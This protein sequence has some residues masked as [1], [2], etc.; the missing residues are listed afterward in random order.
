M[1]L[2]ELASRLG[3]PV[4]GDADFEVRGA[5]ALES[6]GPADLCFVAS[7]RYAAL[8]DKSGAG[9]AILPPDVERGSRPA[10]RSPRPRL[11]FARA[12]R[13]LMPEPIAEPGVHPDASVAP[14][15]RIDPT[16]SV[17][18]R[19][20]V[21]ARSQVGPRSVLHPNATLYEDVEI[22]ADCRIHAGVV[23]RE[24]TLLGDRV[25]LQ[26]GVMIGGDGFGYESGGER[27]FE[28][29][30][31]VGRVVIEDDV[32]IG[33]STTVD[34]APPSTEPRSARRASARG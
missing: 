12:L 33:A 7:A 29:V 15:A 1:R 6:A 28:T 10:I 14:D 19:A 8:L 32:E 3:R 22:G 16:A 13:V 2:G 5:A 26:P 34:R 20:V 31:Q 18:A 30:P 27:H 21:G 25:I 11:D 24:G 17:G 23:L 4:E 9:A